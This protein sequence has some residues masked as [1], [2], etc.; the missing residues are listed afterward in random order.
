[1]IGLP[2][3]YTV[4]GLMFAAFAVL[5]AIDRANPRRFAN[6]AFWGLLALSFLAGDRLGDVGNGVLVLALVGVAMLKL[7]RGAPA[8]TS[9][10]ERM[11]EAAAHRNRLFLPALVV[12]VAALVGT[13]VFKQM[14]AWIDTKQATLVALAIG[15]LIA[16]GICF[17]W[18]KPRLV[19]PLQEGRRLMDA[20][21]WAAVL[22]QMLAALGALFAAAG[23]GNEVGRLLGG[24]LPSNSLIAAVFA[25]GFGMALLTILMGNAF[26]AFPVMTAA[27]GLPLLIQQHHGVPAGVAA[28]G[29]LTG[30]CGT[31]LTPMAANF[32]IVPAALLELPDRYGVIRAQAPTAL[33]MLAINLALM[34]F[35]VFP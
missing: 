30:F 20:V 23:V 18:L 5:G 32:N 14:P 25:Y 8:T 13:L 31:L 35:L 15:V 17:A 7:G 21:G 29:M 27:V 4:G 34:Y 3:V 22:P 6:G 16:L 1:M 19:T 10:G 11:A 24:A 9:P 28:L 2:F 12:P 26:A 33:V